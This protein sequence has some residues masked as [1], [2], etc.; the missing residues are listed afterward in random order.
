MYAWHKCIHL[1][2]QCLAM[3]L[4]TVHHR[5]LDARVLYPSSTLP[6]PLSKPFNKLSP[7]CQFCFLPR[8]R[9]NST[10]LMDGLNHSEP[11]GGENMKDEV[12][13]DLACTLLTVVTRIFQKQSLRKLDPWYYICLP[14][15]IDLDLLQDIC[16]NC[17]IFC[18]S[19]K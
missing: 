4:S 11:D 8:G 10:C 19:K 6:V 14:Y 2:Q 3:I 16:W 18:Q 12:L 17:W 13:L 9:F 5:C 7:P 1:F 15:V